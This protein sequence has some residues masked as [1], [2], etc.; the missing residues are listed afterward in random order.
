MWQRRLRN[1]FL[2]DPF[3][4]FFFLHFSFTHSIVTDGYR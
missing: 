2:A 3:L 1:L 4:W